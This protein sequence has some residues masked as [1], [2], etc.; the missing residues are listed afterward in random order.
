[1]VVLVVLA[2]AL[3]VVAVFLLQEKIAAFN[4]AAREAAKPQPFP[5][6]VNPVEKTI[7][8]QPAVESYL[9]QQFAS[10]YRR[11]NRVA[12]LDSVYREVAYLPW[13]QTLASPDTRILVIF[14]GQ[15]HEEV[16]YNF[17][18]ILG[19]TADERQ[20]FVDLVTTNN[21]Q[22]TDGT[23]Y[24]GRYVVDAEATPGAVAEQLIATFAQNVIDRYP[25][26]L[27]AT[28]PLEQVLTIASLIER[29]ASSFS[30]MRA[31]SGVI[32]NRLFIDMKLQLDATLQ[33]ARGSLPYETKWWPV[34]TPQDKYLDSPFNTYQNIGLPP[35]PIANPSAA[36]I[37]AA[38][39]PKAD[40]CLFYFHDDRG[41]MFCSLTYEEHVRKIREVW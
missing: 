3:T 5:V 14:A 6:G 41:K 29:E 27:E 8:E 16:A 25:E 20:A 21:I 13:Y 32:W 40:E 26:E 24:P 19:W 31:V 23:F 4:A 33:Y 30:D 39:N 28:L 7:T 2:T 1:M 22:L 11:T 12:W 9:R 34:P 15:R 37:I 17:G 10:D 18:Q 36:A 38:L 35:H